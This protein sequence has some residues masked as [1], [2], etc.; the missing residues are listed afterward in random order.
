MHGGATSTADTGTPAVLLEEPEEDPYA[1]CGREAASALRGRAPVLFAPSL[2]TLV[3]FMT[4]ADEPTGWRERFAA[5]LG[6]GGDLPSFRRTA[7]LIRFLAVVTGGHT[8]SGLALDL[9]ARLLDREFGRGRV[10]RFE[11]IDFPAALT[12]EPTRR[13]LREAG[14]PEEAFPFRLELDAPLRTLAEHD[15]D[16]PADHWWDDRLDHGWGDRPDHAWDDRRDD[17]SEDRLPG[18]THRAEHLIRLGDLAGGGSLL[19]DGTTGVV[20]IRSRTGAAAHPLT[21]D[22]STLACTLWLLHR[23]R[24][25]GRPSAGLM[26]RWGTSS[27]TRPAGPVLS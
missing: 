17:A 19:V 5:C 4:A 27:V 6:T 18:P 9:P 22:V 16:D 21:T 23:E 1:G 2:P 26:Q 8:E 10:A 13:F 3:R 14:L 15:A 12:H 24:A 7:D 25:V 20:L 11:E